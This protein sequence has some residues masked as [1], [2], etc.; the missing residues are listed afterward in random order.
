MQLRYGSFTFDTDSCEVTMQIETHTNERG[1]PYAQTRQI[2]VS[3]YLNGDNYSEVNTACLSLEAALKIPY[4]DLILYTDA[5]AASHLALYN[6]GSTTGVVPSGLSY[7]VGKGAELVT[8]RKFSFSARAE[9][10][11][12]SGQAVIQSF[13]ESVS[14]VG[15]GG[16]RFVLKPALTGN[17]QKQIV[18]QRTI[19]RANQS[20]QAV[21]YLDYPAPPQ[22]LWPRDEH[23][24]QRNISRTGGKYRGKA[25]QDFMISWNYTFESAGPLSGLPTLR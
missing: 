18:Q 20:G 15:T 5:G 17:P 16:A 10:P 22:P 1:L 6:T 2:N 25:W 19:V 13:R 3:G 14:I 24:D 8:Y 11:I 21:G 4:R 7:P 9:Y 12:G 23:V